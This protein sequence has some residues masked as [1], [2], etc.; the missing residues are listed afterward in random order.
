MFYYQ[1]DK[2]RMSINKINKDIIEGI[3]NGDE[4][5]FSVLYDCYYTYLNTIAI[6]YLYRRNA[7]NEVVNDVFVNIWANRSNLTYPIHSYLIKSV[8][9]RCLNYLRDLQ[10]EENKTEEYKKHLLVIQEEQIL[11]NPTPLHYME[12]DEIEKLIHDAVSQLPDK[13]RKVFEYYFYQGKSTQ[14]IEQELKININ[15]VRVQIKNAL[16]KLK[17]I[18]P[19]HVFKWLVLICLLT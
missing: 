19:P 8:R 3:S 7:A 13:C 12:T 16:D 14:E 10:L 6:Y 1:N 18:L 2:E 4:K 15:T 9:N 17:I 5:A 11:S